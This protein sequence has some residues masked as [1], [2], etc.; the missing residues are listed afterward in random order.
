[1]RDT[2]YA[3]HQILLAPIMSEKSVNMSGSVAF[4]VHG[5][6]TKD[7]IRSAVEKLFN[8]KVKAVNTLTNRFYSSRIRLKAAPVRIKKK[9]YVTLEAGQELN[10]SS[11]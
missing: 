7:D 6:A 8:V 10:L 2:S 11:I 3:A 4:W 9:A 5:K 1:M